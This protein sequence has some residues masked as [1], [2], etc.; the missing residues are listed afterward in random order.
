MLQSDR[1]LQAVNTINMTPL[2]DLAF[3]LLIIFIIATP[4]LEQTIPLNLPLESNNNAN[5]EDVKFQTI[6][7][8][9]DGQIFWGKTPISRETLEVYLQRF[10]QQSDPPVLN[11]RGDANIRYQAVIDVIDLIK[12]N[13]LERISLDTQVK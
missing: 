12:K 3:A 9:Q 11:I 2:I 4:L 7:I 6:S 5:D 1:R 8:D 10:A 13:N